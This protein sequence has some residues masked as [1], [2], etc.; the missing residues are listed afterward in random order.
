MWTW[1]A[2]S[3][4]L[5]MDCAAVQEILHEELKAEDTTLENDSDGSIVAISKIRQEKN[6]SEIHIETN[7]LNSD[8]KVSRNWTDVF[9]LP[10]SYY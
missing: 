10:Y 5:S 2:W 3:L 4:I 6:F 1:K 8:S 7:D 9:T